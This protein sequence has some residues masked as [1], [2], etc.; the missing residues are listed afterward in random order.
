MSGLSD[1]RFIL[2]NQGCA[3]LLQHPTIG[4]GKRGISEKHRLVDG[5]TLQRRWSPCVSLCSRCCSCW[6][7]LCPSP[8]VARIVCWRRAEVQ[9]R[10]KQAR[11]KQNSTAP[12]T[13]CALL[14]VTS[15]PRR[16]VDRP[17]PPPVRSSSLLLLPLLVAFASPSSLL[18][19]LAAS[20]HELRVSL[21]IHH[22]RRHGCGCVDTT[23][24]TQSS[25]SRREADLPLRRTGSDLH[26]SP[27]LPRRAPHHPLADSSGCPAV[28]C[29]AVLP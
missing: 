17:F 16:P 3:M 7:R 8:S 28:L 26:R 11:R 18:S 21:Q 12:H 9:R 2:C 24:H 19:S 23:R 13:R 25:S 4:C 20:R 5:L 15:P 1:C 27:R 10:A 6:L 14:T 22:H 29:Y